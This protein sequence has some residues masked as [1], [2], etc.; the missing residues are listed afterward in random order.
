MKYIFSKSNFLICD[1]AKLISESQKLGANKIN[2]KIVCFGTDIKEYNSKKNPFP[3]NK[4][5]RII[6][7]GTNRSMEKIYDPLT[8]LKA[9]N[10][11][12]KK[13]K[14]FQFFIANEG[15]LKNQ[16]NNYISKNNLSSNIKLVGRQNGKANI[17]FYQMLDIYVST[18][19]SDGGLAE[20]ISEAMSCK[21]LVIV[22]D[23]SDNSLYVKHGFSGYLFPN[24]D[25]IQLAKLIENAAA[26]P[27]KSIEIAKKGRNIIIKECNYHKEMNKVKKIYSRIYLR[28]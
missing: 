9:A 15:S 26:N 13:K 23:N 12:I 21:R 8:F 22:S 7:I 28:K 2:F 27:N 14:N 24:R 1:S 16:I 11:L 3:L 25:Y 19:L 6:K 5:R 4:N 17:E 18:S 20:S 10:Y